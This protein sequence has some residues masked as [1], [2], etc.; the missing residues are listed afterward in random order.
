M[1]IQ[2]I[3]AIN[4]VQTKVHNN[5]IDHGFYSSIANRLT[6]YA[7]RDRP[8][9]AQASTDDFVIAQLGKIACEA[10]EA[11]DAVQHDGAK[12]HRVLEELADVVIRSL[13]LAAFLQGKLGVEI[14]KK[15]EKNKT[16]PFLHGK[17]C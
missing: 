4:E 8:D 12:G 13:D 16:R 5:A 10:G 3:E 15:H 7:Q 2:E 1:T 14:A 11:I 6:D 17:R 9:L